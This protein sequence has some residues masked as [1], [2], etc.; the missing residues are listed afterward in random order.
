LA[1]LGRAKLLDV[2]EHR[3]VAVY[4][5]Q[6]SDGTFEGLAQGTA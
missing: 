1:D 5:G 6:A 3:H 4:L 2:G